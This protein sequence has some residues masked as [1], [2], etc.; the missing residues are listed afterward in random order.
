M[1]RQGNSGPEVPMTINTAPDRPDIIR[2]GG[3]TIDNAA[4]S[5]NFYGRSIKLT[6]GEFDLLW[7]LAE[8]SG[9]VVTRDEL[10]N[11]LVG[12]EYDGLDRTIDVRISRLRK[13]LESSN[14]TQQLIFAVRSEGY[15]LQTTRQ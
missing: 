3:L 1:K 11:K 2:V 8:N 10:F 15:C 6:W 13:K 12:H 5:V 14:K 4:R 7:Y 9:Q